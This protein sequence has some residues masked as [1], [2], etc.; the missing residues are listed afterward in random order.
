MAVT[1]DKEFEGKVAP[2]QPALFRPMEFPVSSTRDFSR[3]PNGVEVL[4]KIREQFAARFEN[5]GHVKE[6]LR[7]RELSKDDFSSRTLDEQEIDLEDLEFEDELEAERG[8]N[9]PIKGEISRLRRAL[10]RGER[11]SPSEMDR[12]GATGLPEAQ[13]VLKINQQRIDDSHGFTLSPIR[14][15]IRGL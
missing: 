11:L 13:E 1:T 7:K 10:D 14:A 15:L 9:I 5:G 4:E 3:E 12:L 8:S 2:V 6:L